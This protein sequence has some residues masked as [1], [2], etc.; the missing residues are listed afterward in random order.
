MARQIF[1]EGTMYGR[2]GLATNPFYT[3]VIRRVGRLQLQAAQ[4]TSPPETAKPQAIGADILKPHVEL[5][6]N[7]FDAEAATLLQEAGAEYAAE[8]ELAGASS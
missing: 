5:E 7:N 2:N 3:G 1:P 6:L 4:E 8:R